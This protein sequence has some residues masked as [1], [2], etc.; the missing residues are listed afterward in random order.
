MLDRIRLLVL[1]VD[2][3]LSDGRILYDST[4]V[5]TKAFFAADGQGVKYWLRSGHRAAI[6]SGRHSQAV[7]PRAA[8]LGID[9]VRT[10][11]KDKLPAFL[12]LLREAECAAEEVAYVG[13]DL[14]DI[15]AMA[16]AGFAV[17]VPEAPQAVRRLAHY[18]TRAAGGAGAVRETIE[19]LLTYQDRWADV[20]QRYADNLPAHLPHPRR[21]WR[22]RS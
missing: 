13:D 10:G 4:G 15:P 9:L 2:G 11:A 17:A 8:E 1:D 22:A 12:D 18:V 3:V 16:R 7:Q 21:P 20:T 6:L 14:V 5:E 19:L